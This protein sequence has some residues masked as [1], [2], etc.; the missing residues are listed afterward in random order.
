MRIAMAS[1]LISVAIGVVFYYIL[2]N[3]GMDTASV[4]S[5]NSVRL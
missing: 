2:T 1:L 5:G 4:Y 3:L